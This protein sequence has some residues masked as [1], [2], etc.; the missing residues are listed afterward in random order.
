MLGETDEQENSRAWMFDEPTDEPNVEPVP[1]LAVYDD[2]EA[3]EL[4]VTD[5]TNAGDYRN[6]LTGPLGYIAQWSDP[7]HFN[8]YTGVI[9][10]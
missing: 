9:M 1:F 7:L 4:R 10:R 8:R 5:W 2:T 3:R 6:E